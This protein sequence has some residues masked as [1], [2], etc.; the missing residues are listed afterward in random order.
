M[1]DQDEFGAFLVG[2][3]VG[4]L[5]GAVAALLLAPQSGEETRTIIRDKAIELKDKASEE[6]DEAYAQAEAAAS[7][8]RIRFEELAQLTRERADELQRRSAVLLEEQKS[9]ISEV[10]ARKP[11]ETEPPAPAI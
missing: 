10:M 5:T 2:F 11:S 6:I 8:A 3:V 7:E 1:S 9:R 4:G